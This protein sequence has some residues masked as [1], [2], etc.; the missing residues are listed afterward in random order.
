MD[1]DLSL[2]EISVEDDSLLQQIQNEDVSGCSNKSDFSCSPLQLPRSSHFAHRSFASSLGEGGK[3]N[4]D[5]A[6]PCSSVHSNC[7]NKENTNFNKQEVS[8]LNVDRLQMKRKK[9]GAGYN[10]RKSLAWDRAFFTEEGVL[11]PLELSSISG[12]YNNTDR[13]KLSVIHE[14]GRESLSGTREGARNSAD[15]Q[16]LEENLF[17]ALPSSAATE[18]R[19]AGDTLS[20]KYY[21]PSR[22]HAGS[23]NA[24][25]SSQVWT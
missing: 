23:S 14:E 6:T 20:Q 12:N 17:K 19:H 2:M 11:D 8:K 5:M 3:V 13:E 18:E 21:S 7:A 16:V 1:R 24:V 4:K 22:N 9:K 15:L 25:S 10:L